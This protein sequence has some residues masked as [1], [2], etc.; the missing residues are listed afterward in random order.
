MADLNKRD[1]SLWW[2]CCYSDAYLKERKLGGPL[3]GGLQ[4]ERAR[5]CGSGCAVRPPTGG[6][7][8]APR[9]LLLLLLLLLLCLLP[10]AAA[11]AAV[12]VAA[13]A[14]AAAVAVAAAAVAAVAVVAAADGV[15]A[16]KGLW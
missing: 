2:G 1:C 13:A 12:A 3:D 16:G 14:A 11:A 15:G 7:F 9:H 8:G 6:S 4:K 5:G 10:A